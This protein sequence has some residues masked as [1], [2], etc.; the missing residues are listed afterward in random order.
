MARKGIIA[1]DNNRTITIEV[2]E[3]TW[4]VLRVGYPAYNHVLIAQ[5]VDEHSGW[6]R[7]DETSPSG[8]MIFRCR[9]CSRESTTPDIWCAVGETVHL[10]QYLK[11]CTHRFRKWIPPDTDYGK[12]RLK[13]ATCDIFTGEEAGEIGDPPLMDWMVIDTSYLSKNNQF[14]RFI[15]FPE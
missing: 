3:Q 14:F 4:H 10:N 7:L 12:Y 8:K 15:N 13:C 6:E 11:E 1:M 2:D 9:T 5:P